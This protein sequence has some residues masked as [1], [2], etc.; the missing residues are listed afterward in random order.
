MNQG[1]K[2]IYAGVCGL[3]IALGAMFQTATAATLDFAIQ[4][5]LGEVETRRAFQPLADFIAKVTGDKV[6]IHTA[7]D[8]PEYWVNQKKN[9]P[10][11]IMMDNAFL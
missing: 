7:R 2:T 3:G 11:E 9:N 5:I 1:K 4:P 6:V 8:F 10:Y